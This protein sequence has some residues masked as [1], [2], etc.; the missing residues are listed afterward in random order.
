MKASEIRQLLYGQATT[1][2][3]PV[4]RVKE[5]LCDPLDIRLLPR[6]CRVTGRDVAMLTYRT[7]DGGVTVCG[8][9]GML[10]GEQ[11]LLDGWIMLGASSGE[12]AERR[13]RLDTAT[14]DSQSQFSLFEPADQPPDRRQL[15]FGDWLQE[16]EGPAPEAR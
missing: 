13:A 12:A 3:L 9:I 15:T 1:F 10:N 2:A 8:A 6:W 11:A 14:R 16:P 4:A 5:L 7:E